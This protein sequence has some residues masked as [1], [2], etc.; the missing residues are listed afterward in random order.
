MRYRTSWLT[1]T[2]LIIVRGRDGSH[3]SANQ[4]AA[5][6][7]WLFHISERQRRVAEKWLPSQRVAVPDAAMPRCSS[8]IWNDQTSLL[9]PCLATSG[10]A[11]R[12][13]TIMRQVLVPVVIRFVRAV[14]G[15]ADVLRLFVG[16][17]GN[18]CSDS[19]QMQSCH[20]LVKMFRQDINLVLVFFMVSP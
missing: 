13:R 7:V 14:F 10:T 1:R 11:T 19:L 8:L 17:F 16:Q 2:C 15:Y 20:A 3:F 12:P 5:S 18:P 4:G 9:A 6:A